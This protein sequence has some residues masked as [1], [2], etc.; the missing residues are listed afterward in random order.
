M[1]KADA[2]S[3]LSTRVRSLCISIHNTNIHFCGALML[4]TRDVRIVPEANG[5]FG[6]NPYSSRTICNAKDFYVP[7]YNWSVYINVALALYC[8]ALVT[9]VILDFVDPL[10]ETRPKEYI[11][12]AEYGV[13]PDKYYWFILAHSYIMTIVLV[14]MVSQAV[15]IYILLV[16]HACALFEVVG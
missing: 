1:P 6:L 13:D 12:E 9:P 10:N 16:E 14:K 2:P 5:I 8:A 11:Y 7:I 3:P 15:T 4:L